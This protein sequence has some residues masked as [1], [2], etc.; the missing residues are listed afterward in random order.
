MSLPALIANTK[1]SDMFKVISL[2]VGG[3]FLMASGVYFVM[4][5]NLPELL[6]SFFR[7]P[8]VNWGI[9]GFISLAGS[10]AI[11]GTALVASKLNK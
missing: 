5:A 2:I 3:I 10:A 7:L 1:C 4:N 11:F 6:L 9:V 8:N